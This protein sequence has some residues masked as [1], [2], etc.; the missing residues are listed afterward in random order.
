[1]GVMGECDEDGEMTYENYKCQ[2][3]YEWLKSLFS[4]SRQM[5]CFLWPSSV[6]RRASGLPADPDVLGV[7]TLQPLSHS[8]APNALTFAQGQ[9]LG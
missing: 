5:H 4:P 3:F 8:W 7:M 6:T 2:V 9:W 1:M